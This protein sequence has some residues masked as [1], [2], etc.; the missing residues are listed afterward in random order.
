V[1]L[2]VLAGY[3]VSGKLAVLEERPYRYRLKR[4]GFVVAPDCR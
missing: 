4:L 2:D 3:R 1:L